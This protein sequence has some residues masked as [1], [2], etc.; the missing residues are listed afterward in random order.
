M[1]ECFLGLD[2]GTTGARACVLDAAGAII[3]E[4][5]FAY[6]DPAEQQAVDWQAA[7]SDLLAG[8]PPMQRSSLHAVSIDATSGTVLLAD[9]AGRPVGPA[10]LYSDARAQAEARSIAALVAGSHT[11]A[12]AISGL[13]KLL[14]LLKHADS[15]KVSFACHQ[16]DWINGLLCGAFAASDYHNALKTGCDPVAL[17]WPD[18]MQSLPIRPL[19]PQ[20]V[21]PGSVLAPIRSDIV[22]RFGLSRACVVRAGTTDSVAA[23]MAAGIARPGEAVTSLGSTL[24]LKLLSDTRVDSVDAGVYSHRYGRLWLAGGASNTGGAVLRQYFP[25]QQLSALSLQINPDMPSGLDYYPLIGPGERFPIND[26]QL[27]PRLSPR[28]ADDR[29]F[30][31]GLLEAIARIEALGYRKLVEL[32]ANPVERVVTMGGGARNE[33][34]RRIRELLLGVAV[35]TSE[36]GEAAFGAAGLARLGPALLAN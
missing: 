32:G 36:H 18:W 21:A 35:S 20:V 17:A 33:T 31:Q 2:F 23:F 26:P 3:H 11:A 15:D 12:N 29:A 9:A 25:D 19:L 7:L 24:V 4:A 22:R 6:S 30:L 16:A 28:P 10:L 27:A 8:V 34:W 1:T 14:W 5:R 13:S